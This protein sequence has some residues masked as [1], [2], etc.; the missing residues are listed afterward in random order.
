MTQDTRQ[1]LLQAGY[2][3]FMEHGYH[4]AGLSDILAR[5]GVPKGSFY[6]YFKTKEIFLIEVLGFYRQI[7]GE[8]M[9]TFLQDDT[10]PALEQLE[11]YMRAGITQCDEQKCRGGCLA[12]NMAQEVSDISEEL[13]AYIR[14]CMQDWL[15]GIEQ[16]FM[17]A[18][19]Q[20]SL[21]LDHDTKALANMFVDGWQGALLRMKVE[22]TVDPLERFLNS[23]FKILNM[24]GRQFA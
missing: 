9:M 23:F 19:A 17:K 3:A 24:E 21:C 5:A 11:A 4:G 2:D 15:E 7:A 8:K 18:Q 10:R 22:K 1:I 14:S 12:G 20:K 6:H 16:F 13:R